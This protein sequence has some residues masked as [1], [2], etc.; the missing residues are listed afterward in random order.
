MSLDVCKKSETLAKHSLTLIPLLSNTA[1]KM[2]QS[3]IICCTDSWSEQT[4]E[5]FCT[6]LVF[7]ALHLS[8]KIALDTYLGHGIM[9]N[10][11][12]PLSL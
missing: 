10:Q 3:K 5:T 2:G 8:L 4:Q 7:I 9:F 6:Y 12:F 1:V 11:L